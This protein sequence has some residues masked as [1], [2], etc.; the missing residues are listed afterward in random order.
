[1]NYE[2]VKVSS[3][4]DWAD[5]HAIRHEVLFADGSY[6]RNHPHEHIPE[7]H[8]MLLKFLGNAIAT[9]RLDFS[10]TGAC[11]IRLVAV[12]GDQQSKGHGRKLFESIEEYVR[13]MNAQ[14]LYVN[15]APDAVGYYEKMGF[16]K[17]VWDASELE[18]IAEDCIQMT[19]RIVP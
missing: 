6:D 17:Q 10:D 12:K 5:Y 4:Q 15:S 2:F 16:I 14:I 13:T 9:V 18:G 1:M 19:K 8:S 7:N 11:I 3:T